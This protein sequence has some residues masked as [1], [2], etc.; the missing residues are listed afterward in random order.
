MTFAATPRWLI[1]VA[2]LASSIP[3]R[4]ATKIDPL[5]ALPDE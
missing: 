2:L 5:R 1:I 3:A 4:G